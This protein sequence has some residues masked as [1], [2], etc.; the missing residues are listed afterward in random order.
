MTVAVPD[1][2]TFSELMATTSIRLGEGAAGGAVYS[3]VESMDPQTPGSP[4]PVPAIDQITCWLFVPVTP[5]ANRCCPELATIAL[6][7]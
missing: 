5:A 7:G 6:P 3:P 2:L 4:H 1:W